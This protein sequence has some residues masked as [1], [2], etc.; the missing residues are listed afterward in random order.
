MAIR[1]ARLLSVRSFSWTSVLRCSKHQDGQS[2][3]HGRLRKG[4]EVG[5]GNEVEPGNEADQDDVPDGLLTP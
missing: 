1:R 3:V 5:P 4:D 2:L